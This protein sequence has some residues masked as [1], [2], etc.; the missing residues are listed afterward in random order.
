MAASFDDLQ[1]VAAD[2]IYEG[3]LDRIKIERAKR[4]VKS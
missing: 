4:G 1:E 3:M 2:Y